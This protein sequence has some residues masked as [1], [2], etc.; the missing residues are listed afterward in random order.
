MVTIV[1]Y[2]KMDFEWDSDKNLGNIEKHGISFEEAMNAFLDPKRKIRLNTKHS[3]VEMRYYCLGMV[4]S[5]VL[6]VRFLIRNGKVRII[7]A[8]YWREGKK[9]YE[10]E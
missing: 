1:W 6:T 8:G 2:G 7:G 4:E 9:L 5:R 10:Q 3:S